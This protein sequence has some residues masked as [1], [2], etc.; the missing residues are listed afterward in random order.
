MNIAL[1]LA[2]LLAPAVAFPAYENG[3]SVSEETVSAAKLLTVTLVVKEQG[4]EKIRKIST[5]VSDPT[6]PSYGEF[7]TSAEVMALTAPKPEDLR[8]VTEWLQL[9]GVGYHTRHSNVVASMTVATASKL[10]NTE[11]HVAQNLQHGQSLIRASEYE[12]PADIQSSVQTVFGLQGLPLPPRQAVVVK[13]LG[14]KQPANVTPDVLASTY[15][16]SGV[17]VSRGEKNKQ[18]VAEFQGQYMNSTDL[19]KMFAKYVDKYE[20]GTDDAV[21]KFVGEHKENS[22]G[23]EAELDIQYIMGQSVGIKTEFWE[24]PGNDFGA[25]LNQWTS[26]LTIQDDVPLVHSVSYGWQG[27]LSQIHVKESDV[28]TVDSNFQKL[29]AMGISIMISSGDS[30]SGFTEPEPQCNKGAKEVGIDGE[31][32]RVVKDIREYEECCFEAN[33]RKA[34]G[35]SFVKEKKGPDD[36]DKK[37]KKDFCT[38]YKTVTSHISANKSTESG[39]AT[40]APA[41]PV[42]WPSWPASS[43]YVTAV[44]ATRFQGHKVGNP[45]M[46]SDQ[47]GSGGGFSKQFDQTNAQWQAAAVAKYLKTVEPSTLPPAG[48]FPPMG[49][50]TPDVSALG[51]GY[52]VVV[53]GHVTSVGGT[54]ASSPAFS[55]MVSL[56]NEARLNAGKKP[57]GLLNPFLYQNEDAFTDVTAGSNKVGRGGQPLPYGWNC[58]AGWDPATGLGTP[59]FAKLLAAAMK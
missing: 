5:A 30:G 13:S 15:G 42:L 12:L 26:N 41:M 44:G 49:R 55:S 2:A 36:T 19:A 23:I 47:F 14:P 21:Y 17:K 10:F 53:G 45:E 20:E 37:K 34:A 40:T 22:G 57:M 52:Q 43:P 18:A 25:D 28:E 32:L 9:N 1:T 27:N 54:S 4:A 7:L 35:W 51:E 11:F 24:F 58:S 16:I 31:V 3:W 29:S 56:L 8:K 50:A 33:E 46:A 39:F 59:Q 6:S 38:L 48:S